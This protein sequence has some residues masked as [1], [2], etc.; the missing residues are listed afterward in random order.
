MAVE[1]DQYDASNHSGWSV[2]IK[3]RAR[4]LTDADEIEQASALRLRPW[5]VDDPHH[6]LAVSTDLVSGR[7]ID[8]PR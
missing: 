5:G 4:E 6:Y 1:A 7:R 8:R 2:V 3:G